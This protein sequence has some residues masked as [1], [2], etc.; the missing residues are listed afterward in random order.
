MTDFRI[1]IFP[2]LIIQFVQFFQRVIE[3]HGFVI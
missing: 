2:D 3:P 1:T